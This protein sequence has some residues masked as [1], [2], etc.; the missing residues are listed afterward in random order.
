MSYLV[1]WRPSAE[2]HLA[3]LWMNATDRKALTLAADTIDADLA[4]DPFAVGES[5]SGAIRIYI[6]SPL[7]VYY[8]VDAA[9]QQVFVWAVWSRRSP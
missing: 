7:A 1:T 8:T 5:R 6:V 3:R 4:R 9:S 2:Q